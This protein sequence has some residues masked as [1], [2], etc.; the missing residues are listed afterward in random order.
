VAQVLSVL[1]HLTSQ[2]L[3]FAKT[4]LT[5]MAQRAVIFVLCKWQS[6]LQNKNNFSEER[7]FIWEGLKSVFKAIHN[8][9][10]VH[11]KH[12]KDS[13]SDK[14]IFLSLFSSKTIL[15]IPAEKLYGIISFDSYAIIY[16]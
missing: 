2:K 8:W 1:Q 15:K 10:A 12:L 9:Q 14:W 7:H 16:M 6:D 13:H 3:E 4:I 11:S 5:K